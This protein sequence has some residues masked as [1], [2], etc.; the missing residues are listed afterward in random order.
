M[1]LVSLI[2]HFS[3][4]E[5]LHLAENAV[6]LKSSPLSRHKITKRSSRLEM[7]V[8]KGVLKNSAE[9]TGKYS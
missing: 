8:K 2:I 3:I 6:F 4:S 5:K 7:S 1:E 9:F